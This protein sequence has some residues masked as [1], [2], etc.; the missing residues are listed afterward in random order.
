MTGGASNGGPRR[1]IAFWA[2]ALVA[3]APLLPAARA[4]GVA[5]RS[6]WAG[7]YTSDQAMRGGPLYSAS[8]GSCH[9]LA[10]EG[11]EMAPALSG[12]PFN[13]NWNGLTLGDLLERIR[14]SMPQN[15]PGSL[16]RQAYVDILAFML[17]SGSFPEGQSELPRET[18]FLKQITFESTKP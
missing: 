14:I 9:G 5:P 11:G 1:T 4:Q 7:V 3:V 13:A 2:L 16:S 18:E 10:L 17:R 6:V 15:S 12:G 8:C